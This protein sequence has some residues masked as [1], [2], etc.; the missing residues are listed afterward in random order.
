MPPDS[1]QAIATVFLAKR[2]RRIDT[3][4]RPPRTNRFRDRNPHRVADLSTSTDV[5][6]GTNVGRSFAIAV[7]MIAASAFGQSTATAG[8]AVLIEFASKQCGPCRAMQPL[9][10]Q[11]AAGG[12][13][14]RTVD[15]DREPDLARRYGVRET[16]TFLV[17]S[18]GKE[19]TR[20]VGM[21]SREQL[22][23]AMAINPSGPLV[24]THSTAQ[25]PPPQTRLAPLPTSLVPP[26]SAQ[27]FATASPTAPPAFASNPS[28]PLSEAMPSVAVADA[29]ERAQAA[30]V[31]LRVYDGTGHGVGTG[32]IIDTH[33]DEALVLT[34]GHLFRDTQGQG[35]IEVDVFI[36][37]RTQMIPGQ[38]IDYDADDR[39]IALVAIRPGY[40]VQPV[41]VVRAGALP[42]VGT[43]AF[44]FGCDRGADPSRRDTRVTGVNK[45]NQH[46]GASNL[47]IAG[48]PIDGRSGGGLF[49]NDGYLIGV[50]NAADYQGDIGIY[51]GPGAIHWQ[52]DRLQLSRLYQSGGDASLVSTP[53]SS[54][55][56]SA[57]NTLAPPDRLASLGGTAGITPQPS[58]IDN[59]YLGAGTGLSTGGVGYADTQDADA[60][61]E[62]IIII[63]DRGNPQATP[64]VMTVP[65]PSGELMRIL[66]SQA[67]R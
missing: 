46:K 14:V 49:S 33:G 47:E 50:C 36:G 39:D 31:R 65:Q 58:A 42:E 5:Q 26:A 51:A 21:Q 30:T 23:A 7:C 19:L 29:V 28:M 35:R 20:L 6:G 11:L 41:P 63:R 61:S 55:P 1:T 2:P 44:S 16:P 52:L 37:G 15:V 17:V 64:R 67:A 62:V 3:E 32:T 38:L 9:I 59:S 27:T 12:V 25:D 24:P 10:A 18:G 66:E 53:G 40:P 56:G 22:M 57:P 43:S 4:C 54:A 45:F 13:A 34:C 8:D 48:A 60:D